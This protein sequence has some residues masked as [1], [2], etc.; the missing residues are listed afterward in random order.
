MTSQ[1]RER[2]TAPGPA[3]QAAREDAPPRYEPPRVVRSGSLERVT[4]AS[5]TIAPGGTIGGD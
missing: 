3:R 4:L 2:G 1:E 5:G